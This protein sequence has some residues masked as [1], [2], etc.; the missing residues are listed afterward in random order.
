MIRTRNVNMVDLPPTSLL[1]FVSIHSHIPYLPHIP[2]C[3][4]LP[5]LATPPQSHSPMQTHHLLSLLC[6]TVMCMATASIYVHTA[7]L[8]S[9]LCHKRAE[10]IMNY[11]TGTLKIYIV[12]IEILII[13]IIMLILSIMHIWWTWI[14]S[15]LTISR[16]RIVSWS[17]VIHACEY[18]T[19]SLRSCAFSVCH[20]GAR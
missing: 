1:P 19:L 11:I 18:G 6:H 4:Y 17:S 10:V 20:G 5:S 2:P 8:D 12:C 14:P 9:S 3:L 15:F 7:Q 13:I 16:T